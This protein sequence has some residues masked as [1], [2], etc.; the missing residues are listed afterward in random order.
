M[1]SN[2][3]GSTSSQSWLWFKFVFDFVR[4][5][6]H[7]RML[8]FSFLTH[9]EASFFNTHCFE[10]WSNSRQRHLQMTSEKARK[11]AQRSQVELH[12]NA[13]FSL[14]DLRG[15]WSLVS[16]HFP[17]SSSERHPSSLTFSRIQKNTAQIVAAQCRGSSPRFRVGR[18]PFAFFSERIVDVLLASQDRFLVTIY[19]L[20]CGERIIEEVSP[21]S[22]R[23]CHSRRST[24]VTFRSTRRKAAVSRAF[25]C[26][27]V[28]DPARNLGQ[29]VDKK[30]Q[31]LW[32][33]I[34]IAIWEKFLY[35]SAE[36]V[37]IL[38]KFYLQHSIFL[39]THSFSGDG[40]KWL[41]LRL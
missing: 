12:N 31:T 2:S 29:Y 5:A 14:S 13:R 1:R 6:R 11:L 20:P 28:A 24:P 15:V 35:E 40:D 36:L 16:T 41:R 25:S 23:I 26:S 17:S 9:K 38:R 37:K 32:K 7:Q 33:N 39:C 21:D 8:S 22:P 18:Q 4:G 10:S 30:P 3:L 27:G 34:M 19:E